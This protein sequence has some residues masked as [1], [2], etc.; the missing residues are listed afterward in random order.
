MKV[1]NLFLN[2]LKV[3]EMETNLER[4]NRGSGVGHLAYTGHLSNYS[5]NLNECHD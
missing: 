2:A 4:V 5:R 1:I 3:I